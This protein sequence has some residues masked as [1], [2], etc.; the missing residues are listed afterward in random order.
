MVLVSKQAAWK[1][2]PRI[3]FDLFAG[4]GFESIRKTVQPLFFT[5]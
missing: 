4:R 5:E 2:K 3:A 1:D